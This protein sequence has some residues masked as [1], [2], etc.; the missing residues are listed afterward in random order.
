MG[1]KRFFLAHR[2]SHKSE[3]WQ[4]CALP[5]AVAAGGDALGPL[6]QLGSNQQGE[7]LDLQTGQ[8]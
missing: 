4:S 7:A 3:K 6:Q 5:P 1:G 8:V 2:V